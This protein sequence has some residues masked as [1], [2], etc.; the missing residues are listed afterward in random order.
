[1]KNPFRAILAI[2]PE[3]RIALI[4]FAAVAVLIAM[5]S[6]PDTLVTAPMYQAGDVSAANIKSP[7]DLLV[8]DPAATEQNR[9]RAVA[10]VLTV[11]DFDETLADKTA[12]R[13]ARAF[14]LVRESM[15]K[16]EQKNAEYEARFAKYEDEKKAYEEKRKQYEARLKE[17]KQKLGEEEKAEGPPPP[18]GA[19]PPP[20]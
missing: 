1:M 3:D 5:V 8:K 4:L 15:E 14:G 2:Q 9:K 12:G 6:H 7:R 13:I 10:S 18:P 11:Y 19:P 16:Q 17:N 20:P